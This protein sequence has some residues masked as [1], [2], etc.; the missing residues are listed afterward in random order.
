[1]R[2]SCPWKVLANT[3]VTWIIVIQEP[4]AVALRKTLEVTGFTEAVFMAYFF[5]LAS[6]SWSSGD[7]LPAE[8]RRFLIRENIYS[9]K[10]SLLEFFGSLN[11]LKLLIF[12]A[13]S[14]IFTT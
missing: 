3:K 14:L 2:V 6:K 8:A 4:L 7:L 12:N 1:M 5:L 9:R 13:L 10:V 11:I